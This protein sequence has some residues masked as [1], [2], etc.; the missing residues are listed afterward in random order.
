MASPLAGI[1]V[2][3]LTQ[4]LAGPYCTY[5]LALLGADVI[6]IEPPGQ[7]E[8]TRGQGSFPGL[9][10]HGLSLGFCVQNAQKR[11]LTVNLKEPR[12]IA[13][14]THLVARADVF[15]ENFRPGVADRLGLGY[16]ALAARNPRLVYASISAY[17][18]DGP[19]GHR[20]AYDHVVQAMAGI[21]PTTGMPGSEPTKVGAP[22]IDYAAGLQGAFAIT[23]ALHERHRTGTGQRVDVAMLDTALLLMA[24]HLVQVA[25]TGENPAKTGNEAFSGAPSSGCYATQDGLLMLAANTERQFVALCTALGRPDLTTDPRFAD[26]H[27]RRH[28]QE[29]LRQA[30]ATVFASNT[31]AAW[32]ALLDAAGVPAAKVRTIRE[33][34]DEGQPAARGL[35]TAVRPVEGGPDVRVPTA[36]F[37]INSAVLAPTQPPRQLGTDTEAILQQLGYT[38]SEI[39]TLRA[40]GVV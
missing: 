19:L 1:T 25:M 12:G 40:D 36:G 3:D 27:I 28:N 11:S 24:N 17:G 10:E 38:A 39:A 20:G 4:V 35:L 22:Y 15:V 23:A 37:K 16:A 21:M 6:K 31:A 9:S 26:R 30:F 33:V 2:V 5:Q 34:L 32:E 14:V 29:A 13:I 7:G 18:Q 8:W